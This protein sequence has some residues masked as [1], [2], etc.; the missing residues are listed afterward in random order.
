MK[1]AVLGL[2]DFASWGKIDHTVTVSLVGSSARRHGNIAPPI[3]GLPSMPRCFAYHAYIAFGS[4]ALKKMP[5]RPMT[6]FFSSAIPSSS[7]GFQILEFRIGRKPLAM[8]R[9][10]FCNLTSAIAVYGV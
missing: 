4:L 2:K 5:P 9:R 1:G 8:A 10:A 7:G 3:S 6:R